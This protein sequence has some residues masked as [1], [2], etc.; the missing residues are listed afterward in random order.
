MSELAALV[1][2]VRLLLE[3]LNDPYP[4]PRS[5]LVPD[6]GPAASKYVPCE[7]CRSRGQVRVRSGWKLCLVCA[8]SGE[9]VRE[10]EPEW[11][12][13]LGMPLKDATSL[14][15]ESKARAL[16][17]GDSGEQ[18]FAWERAKSTHDRH[19][20][21]VAI[22]RQL[23]WLSVANPRR[24]HLI[25]VLLVD[26]EPVTVSAAVELEL[27]LGVLQIALRV[28]KV[29][30]PPWLVERGADHRQASIASLALEGMTAG[31]IARRL[32]LSRKAVQRKIR[33]QAVGS[34]RGRGLLV[35]A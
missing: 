1:H 4:T 27:E 20:S 5:A 11:D 34:S 23:A 21:Y 18:G 31:Q 7:T 16:T 13:Y 15:V 6:S 30:V 26:H 22:R 29:R 33:R 24:H 8:G 28:G 12:A 3:T 2:D 17:A 10:T 32:G 9:K 25:R 14:V 35:S 19:G